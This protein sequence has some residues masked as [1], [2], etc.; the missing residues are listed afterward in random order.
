MVIIVLFLPL[1]T[2]T[3]LSQVKLY[4]K[5]VSRGGKG[6]REGLKPSASSMHQVGAARHIPSKQW[7]AIV[8]K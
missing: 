7:G 1:A 3:N 6:Y 5:N 8:I 4:H 2:F